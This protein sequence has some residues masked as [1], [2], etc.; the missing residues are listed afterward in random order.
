M[1][2][3]IPCLATALATLL[4]IVCLRNWLRVETP[5]PEVRE[6][7]AEG[8]I[9]ES[10]A[11]EVLNKRHA[12]EIR[13]AK[14][15]LLIGTFKVF[16]GVVVPAQSAD[17]PGF[18]GPLRDNIADD[19]VPLAENW[20][21][22]GPP[23]LW[24][25]ELGNGHAAPAVHRGRVY[26]LDYDEVRDGDVLRCFALD[27]GREIWQRFYT[28]KVRNPHGFSRTIPAVT[29]DC[30][31]SLGPDGKVLCV[32]TTNGAF[33]W[34]MDLKDSFGLK[35]SPTWGMGQCPLID[36]GE[37]VLAPAGKLA[38]LVG[39]D[40]AT[41]KT[42]WIT[43][44]TS[45]LSMSHSSVMVLNTEGGRQF[46]YAALGGIVG[47][48]ADG[49]QRG[50]LLWQTKAFAASV[51]APSPV[52]LP[53]GRFFMT[54]GYASGCA[55]FRVSR[56]NGTWQTSLLFRTNCTTFASEQ[57]TPILHEDLLFTIMTND[58]GDHRQEFACMKTDGTPLW[59][60]GSK[61]RFGGR[62]DGG[63]GPLLGV[64]K[65]RFL[66]LNDASGELSFMRAD[67][68]GCQLLA[69]SSFM[70]GANEG[71]DAWGPMV[72]VDGRL[73]LRDVHR[74]YCLDLRKK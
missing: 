53:D 12:E 47:V 52:P 44:N 24:Q 15:N 35:Q 26:L 48:A 10:N 50:Q 22:S 55:M 1:Q 8:S 30:I 64:G 16:P 21:A 56:S 36:K 32:A 51:L 2:R 62:Q 18:R 63:L 7:T 41:G 4:A 58:K 74:L 19:N 11:V 33:R 57:Q 42:N 70:G 34:G 20:P 67:R 40:L 46:L 65:D 6:A 13:N 45:N 3:W 54:A 23:I 9:A 27:S 60:S 14:T 59:Y 71:H 25:M 31:V 61:L 5:L 17:W 29:D 69:S 43:P 72:L 38:L 49:P 66:L 73:L 68:T 28:G 37:V 39:M